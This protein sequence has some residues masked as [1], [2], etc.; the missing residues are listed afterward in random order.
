MSN[1]VLSPEQR[2]ALKEKANLIVGAVA[3]GDTEKVAALAKEIGGVAAAEAAGGDEGAAYTCGHS[4]QEMLAQDAE[5]GSGINSGWGF[6][7]HRGDD[8]EALIF[9]AGAM[10]VVSA[11]SGHGKTKMLHNIMLIALEEAMKER[12]QVW[13]FH[14][15]ESAAAVLASLINVL[16]AAEVA[17]NNAK[18]IRYKMHHPDKCEEAIA[19]A[20]RR[21]KE[22]Y[23]AGILQIISD[24]PKIEKIKRTVEAANAQGKIHSVFIDY[25]QKLHAERQFGSKKER[26]EYVCDTIN[27]LATITGLPIIVG[28]QF[29]RCVLSPVDME[30]QDNADASNIEQTAALNI[31]LWSSAWKFR[32]GNTYETDKGYSDEAAEINK[33]GF[34]PNEAGTLYINVLKGRYCRTGIWAVMDFNGNTG[35]ISSQTEF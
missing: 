20:M 3:S 23:E 16:A 1:K 17:D 4:W 29:N 15:E 33:V 34:T 18:Y 12:R 32:K 24:Y 9:P 22:W 30:L 26:L 19:D 6:S 7:F 11:P 2:A 28:S 35:K 13:L 8:S 25:M 21:V 10:S 31:G 14:Y 27:E 5:K